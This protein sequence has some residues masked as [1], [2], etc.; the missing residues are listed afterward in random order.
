MVVKMV[1]RPIAKLSEEAPPR[2]TTPRA[3]CSD[4]WLPTILGSDLAAADVC[5]DAVPR[6]CMGQPFTEMDP[7][8][9]GAA[10][11]ARHRS[12]SAI[13]LR[14]WERLLEQ[15]TAGCARLGLARIQIESLS[16]VRYCHPRFYRAF[17]R[18]GHTGRVS[19]PPPAGFPLAATAGLPVEL[20][21]IGVRQ[22]IGYR[23]R[24]ARAATPPPGHAPSL[25]RR[26]SSPLSIYA[27]SAPSTSGPIR[28]CR[29]GI[30]LAGRPTTR[31][32]TTSGTDDWTYGIRPGRTDLGS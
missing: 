30:G 9:V 20:R 32:W 8:N 15:E 10:R 5:R 24:S 4:E 17:Q 31:S 19:H 13:E 6:R 3:R 21:M 22:F 28:R 18:T 14:L 26:R 7:L 11:N 27:T 23:A 16:G 2:M 1:V 25:P 29:R 12:G